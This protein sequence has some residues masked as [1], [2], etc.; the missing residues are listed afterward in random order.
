MWCWVSGQAVSIELGFQEAFFFFS[1][2]GC[3]ALSRT[4]CHE[5]CQWQRSNAWPSL[6]S[7]RTERASPWSQ[8]L[9]QR[10]QSC[11]LLIHNQSLGS[12]VSCWM[13]FLVFL[14]ERKRQIKFLGSRMFFLFLSLSASL[15]HLT[16]SPLPS[17][18]SLWV[19]LHFLIKEALMGSRIWPAAREISSNLRNPKH[20][21][22]EDYRENVSS[23]W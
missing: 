22:L 14:C 3:Q 1:I 9:T 7:L 11:C 13:Q 4:W 15:F 17:S 16:C 8:S 21:I 20:S 19:K 5:P 12:Y 10:E 2:S 18:F 6:A 23:F